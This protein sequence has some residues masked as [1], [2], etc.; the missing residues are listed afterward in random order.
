VHGERPRDELT[1]EIDESNEGLYLFLVRWSGPVCYSSDLDQIHFDLIV[2][3]DD[4]KILNPSFLKLVFL[5]SKIE[6]VS[7]HPI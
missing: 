1:M 3:D 6:L 7:T 4:P 5:R 2:R